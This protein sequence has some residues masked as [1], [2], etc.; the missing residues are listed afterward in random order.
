[1]NAQNKELVEKYPWLKPRNAWTGEE[2]ED[3]DYEFTL[4]D[5]IPE[6]WRIAFG[7]KMVQELDDLLKKYNIR[8][9]INVQSS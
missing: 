1:M 9:E 5:D 7:D 8:D 6:G 4:M 3:Y 2:L